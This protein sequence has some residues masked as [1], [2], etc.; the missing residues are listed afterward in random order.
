MTDCEPIYE[1]L[2]LDT[3]GDKKY[4]T[5][6]V[7]KSYCRSLQ[8]LYNKS[9]E[10]E[11]Q[12]S[13]TMRKRFTPIVTDEW[14]SWGMIL[15]TGLNAYKFDD[16]DSGDSFSYSFND[17]GSGRIDKTKTTAFIVMDDPTHSIV[18]RATLHP[19]VV[20]GDFDVAAESLG[21]IGD[22][23]SNTH[24]YIGYDRHEPF[25]INRF[26]QKDP[27]NATMPSVARAQTFKVEAGKG[28]HLQNIT[29]NLEYHPRP[30]DDLFIELR[31]TTGGRPADTIIA[32]ERLQT[33]T[34]K[35]GH[36]QI[37]I[38]FKT[39]PELIAGETYAIVVRSPITT[40]DNHYGIGGWGYYCNQ[41]HGLSGHDPYPDGYS[42][43]SNDNCKKWILH[44]K[45]NAGA[46]LV[47]GEGKYAPMDFGFKVV[48]QAPS[49]IN[50]TGGASETLYLKP[51][52]TKPI[53]IVTLTHSDVYNDGTNGTIVYSVS[54]DGHHWHALNAGN[55]YEYKF[56]KT[57]NP[58]LN[59]SEILSTHVWVKAVLSKVG[60]N[61]HAPAIQ[62][63][64][65]VTH[66]ARPTN[67]YIRTLDYNPRK[68]NPLGLS[69][70]SGVNAPYTAEPNTDCNVDIVR[71]VIKTEWVEC[72]GTE[73]TFT[74]NNY[75]AYPMVDVVLYKDT[76][77]PKTVNLFEWEDF[78]I[79]SSNT[80]LYDTKE[81]SF[82]TPPVAGNLKIRYYPTWIRDLKVENF[83]LRLDMFE[84]TFTGDLTGWT[85]TSG[86]THTYEILDST[87]HGVE[88]VDTNNIYTQR[89]SVDTV[90][91]Y[92]NSYW[93]NT[94]NGKLYI[95]TSDGY[96]PD[97]ISHG[98][99]LVHTGINPLLLKVK[100][101][102]PL[103]S[104]ISLGEETVNDDTELIEDID[105]T[106]NY[107]N[108]LVTPTSS[109]AGMTVKV[110][111]TPNLPDT[112]ISIVYRTSRT[113]T[114]NQLYVLPNYMEYKV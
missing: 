76:G 30:E 66:N 4:V 91:T 40:W 83:P 114:T 110:K 108:G 45:A 10:I 39:K 61:S 32:R 102:D 9:G 8:Y 53:T 63:L 37:S 11:D 2:G 51:L 97:D 22:M 17:A 103:R 35:S 58:S 28:G 60:T 86:K 81:I 92:P 73:D 111:Y 62:Q 85:L 54:V 34:F 19:T 23:A 12:L 3:Y 79:G 77:S 95:H 99:R 93:K 50:Y 104:I 84:E 74:L 109:W 100:P 113:N 56:N 42:F 65:V 16:S 14:K 31:P 68:S 112:G 96:S 70:W 46:D 82:T 72:N 5:S 48:V 43:T 78:I 18:G 33:K 38:P 52:R 24:W 80:I 64:G 90:E 88:E 36:G 105:F 106:V 21:P 13:P 107:N 69:V 25:V 67:G 57:D 26:I 41:V 101:T 94:S 27:F 44:D 20:A 75:P 49:T 6:V 15:D 71:N 55:N 89:S 7:L 1:N 47:Y 87:G 59:D 98:H 29:L